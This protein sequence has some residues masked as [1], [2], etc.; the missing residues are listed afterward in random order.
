MPHRA[1]RPC[2]KPGC[3]NLTRNGNYC[4]EHRKQR[5]QQVEGRRLSANA[6]GYTYRWQ[7]ARA[8]YLAA[9]PLCVACEAEGRV[10][11]AAEVDHIVP[12]KGD[13]ALFW[14]Q[15]N[16]Q[17]LCKACH[18]RKTVEDGRFGQKP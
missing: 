8:A 2:L 17:A 12:H 9:H 10:T 7:Q 4:Q 18:S 1:P 3:R 14:D 11:A 13:E 16:W 5:L 15:E 6:R